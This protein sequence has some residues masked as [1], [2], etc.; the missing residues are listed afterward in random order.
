M[1]GAGPAQVVAA[2]TRRCGGTFSSTRQ[3]RLTRNWSYRVAGKSSPYRGYVS[4]RGVP[5]S[6]HFYSMGLG[7]ERGGVDVIGSS[8]SYPPPQELVSGT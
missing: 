5:A 4:E 6:H 2:T 8:Q 3:L 1:A 7:L